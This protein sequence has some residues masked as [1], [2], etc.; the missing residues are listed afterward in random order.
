MA[1]VPALDAVE[2]VAGVGPLEMTAG[3]GVELYTTL[4]GRDAGA[5]GT[6]GTGAARPMGALVAVPERAGF[7][8]IMAACFAA[9][10][11]RF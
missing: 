5:K 10:S 9:I 7:F 8:F 2:G 11:A 3:E 1:G 6:F 4:D